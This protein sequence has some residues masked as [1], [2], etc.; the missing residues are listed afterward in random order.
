MTLPSHLIRMASRSIGVR[1]DEV[2]GFDERQVFNALARL[3]RDG[4]LHRA[5]IAHRHVRYFAHATM[6][7]VFV[8]QHFDLQARQESWTTMIHPPTAK[9]PWPANAP[10]IT[11]KGLRIQYGPTF[12]PRFQEHVMPFVHGGLRCA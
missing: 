8:A 5:K 10:A 4:K 11:P 7:D 6:R 3:A 1:A 2:T 12:V 9:A